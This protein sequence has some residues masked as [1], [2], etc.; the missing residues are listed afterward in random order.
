MDH[1][2]I[3]GTKMTNDN[4]NL[5]ALCQQLLNEI[6]IDVKHYIFPLKRDTIYIQER[7]II[8]TIM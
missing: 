5:I 4:N 6:F 1:M 3:L 7:T 2:R 8:L